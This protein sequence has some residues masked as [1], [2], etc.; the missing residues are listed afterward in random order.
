MS[1]SLPFLSHSTLTATERTLCC[2]LENYQT[3]DGVMVPE[4]LRP[5]MMGI[6]FIPFR[7]GPL[8]AVWGCLPIDLHSGVACALLHDWDSWT[9]TT[10]SCSVTGYMSCMDD[11]CFCTWCNTNRLHWGFFRLCQAVLPV[12]QFPAPLTYAAL[13][14]VAPFSHLAPCRKM[15]DAKGKLVDR[16]KPAAEAP[17]ASS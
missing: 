1:L 8:C 17:A 4:V 16:P 14:H 13:L 10:G 15:Y 6:E 3:P 11:A 2:L 7:C 9:G 12:L 5:F